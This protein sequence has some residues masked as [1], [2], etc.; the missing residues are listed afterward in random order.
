MAWNMECHEM[1]LTVVV[2]LSCCL[3]ILSSSFMDAQS[4]TC[5]HLMILDESDVDP[6][7]PISCCQRQ[8]T[9]ALIWTGAFVIVFFVLS[10]MYVMSCYVM[11][12]HVMS[13]HD[14]MI[15]CPP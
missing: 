10:G 4:I 8:T 1:A 7:R 5:Y 15:S 11:L 12:C 14:K 9:Q 13:C 6:D 2:L 3:V